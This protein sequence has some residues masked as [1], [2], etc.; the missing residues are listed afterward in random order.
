M[1]IRHWKFLGVLLIPRYVEEDQILVVKFG[2]SFEVDETMAEDG[3]DG[4]HSEV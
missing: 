2:Y 4:E 1:K 3:D